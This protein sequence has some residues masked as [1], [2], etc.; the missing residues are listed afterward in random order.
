MY[1]VPTDII[2]LF[3]ILVWNCIVIESFDFRIKYTYLSNLMMMNSFK[4]IRIMC[5]FKTL[6]ICLFTLQV[7]TDLDKILYANNLKP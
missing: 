6:S 3:L 4:Y 1:N 5:V 2:I 7:L